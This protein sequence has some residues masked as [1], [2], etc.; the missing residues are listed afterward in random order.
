[1]G[2]L[3]AT[4]VKAV[5]R[6]GRHGD[7]GGLFLM[8]STTGAKSWI[9]RVQKN[10][11][12]R[13]IGLGSATKVSL[14]QAR[15]RA[16]EVRGWIEM[17]LDPVFEKRKARGIPTFSEAAAKVSAAT[18]K[19]WRNEKHEWQ[20]RRTLEQFVYPTIGNVMVS[21]ITG[22][23]VR[24]VLAEIWL[25]K[26]ETA[27]RVRQ[28]IG[29]VLD[30]AYANGYRETE[31][32]MPSITKGLPRQPRTTDTMS[33]CRTRAWQGFWPSCGKGKHSGD[34]RLNSRS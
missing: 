10:G 21:E 14:A 33:R 24:N 32:P 15:K 34:W 9:C 11:R 17:G 27:R 29:A 22:P 19:T 6:A 25:S 3:S 5:S 1:M 8:V 28:R 7:G 18:Q 20:W 30:W 26:P 2:K 12:R 4:T 13:D 23:M 31:A 16:D